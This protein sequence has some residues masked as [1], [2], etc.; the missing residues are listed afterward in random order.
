MRH[1][2]T[3]DTTHAAVGAVSQNR[4]REV[5][6]LLEAALRP[7]RR[8]P[9]FFRVL[10]LTQIKLRMSPERNRTS[11]MTGSVRPNPAE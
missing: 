6:Q 7:A 8:K 10:R 3:Y 4:K 9:V 11:A 2:I 5:W 1:G